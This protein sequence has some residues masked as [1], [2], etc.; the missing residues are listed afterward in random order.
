ML[1]LV[2]FVKIMYLCSR[3]RPNNGW[4][5]PGVV[6]TSIGEIRTYVLGRY[7]PPIIFYWSPCCQRPENSTNLSQRDLLPLNGVLLL[8]AV[9]HRKVV[10]KR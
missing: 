5:I 9:T 2:Y 3:N 1:S 7:A 8:N 10:A 6:S 4:I